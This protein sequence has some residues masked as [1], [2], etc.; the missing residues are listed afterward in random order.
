MTKMDMTDDAIM[1]QGLTF[2]YPGA[3]VDALRDINFSVKRGEIFGFL[4]PSGAGKSTT[5]KILCGLLDG[6]SGRATVVGENFGSGFRGP[7]GG[8]LPLRSRAHGFYAS[9]GVAFEFP[10]LYE[11]FTAREN[12][13][14]FASFYPGAKRDPVVL[15]ER[16]GLRSAIDKRV[17]AFSKGMRVRLNLARALLHEPELLFLDEPTSGLDPGT[18]ATVKDL[19]REERNRGATVFLTTHQMHV[20]DE[21]CDRVAFLVDGKIASM[22]APRALKSRFGERFLRVDW[23]EGKEIESAEYPL[24]DLADNEAFQRRLRA[25][26]VET[27]HSAEASLEDIFMKLTGRSLS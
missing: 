13:E 25:E 3:S 17:A 21:L 15:L 10:Y 20:A 27:M 9:I 23:G 19:I 2:R 5:L 7:L 1:V 12:L 6:F 18:A 16:L 4:G 11:R 14:F 22:D 26:R 8:I 24:E